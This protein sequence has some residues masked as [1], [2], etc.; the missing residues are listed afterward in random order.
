MNLDEVLAKAKPN[1]ATVVVFL[2][3]E[4]ADRIHALEVD[5]RN[6]ELAHDTIGESP[7]VARIRGDLD[8]ARAQAAASQ[9][10]FRL[11]AI[12]S[13]AW[14]RLL[15]EHPP[16]DDDR[17]AGTDHNP[18]TFPPAALAASLVEPE[19][20]VE[21]VEQLADTISFGQWL[22]LWTTCLN[23]NLGLGDRPKSVRRSAGRL[24]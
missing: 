3:G 7:D 9:V 5:L 12:G 22:I 1:T 21:Q 24:S 16:T 14:A 18:R 23:V 20:T 13:L 19:A 8:E 10:E 11:Q 2:D 17:K 15:A 4:I 6:A